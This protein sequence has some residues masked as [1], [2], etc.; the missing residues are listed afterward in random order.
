MINYVLILTI[1]YPGKEWS[2]QGD[3]YEGLNWLD[4]SPKPTQAELDALW[5][6]TQNKDLLNKCETQAQQLLS[7]TDWAVLP[8]VNLLN[9]LDFENYRA[10]VR[11]LAINPIANPVFP[12]VPTAKWSS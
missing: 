12:P 7:N 3:S 1:N 9:K 5:E 4:A 2:L 8:D 6:S 10:V 11:G